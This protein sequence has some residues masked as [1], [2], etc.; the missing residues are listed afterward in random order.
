MGKAHDSRTMTGF[1]QAGRWVGSQISMSQV[2]KANRERGCL[3]FS[4]CHMGGGGKS[5]GGRSEGRGFGGWRLVTL[6]ERTG[7]G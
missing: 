6:P 7:R 1:G 2:P 5:R 4:R 3:S